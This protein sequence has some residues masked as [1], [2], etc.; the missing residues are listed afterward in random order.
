LLVEVD[1]IRIKT[2][3]NE[4][5]EARAIRRRHRNTMA[6]AIRICVNLRKS[7]VQNSDFKTPQKGADDTQPPAD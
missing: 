5:N 2:E 6:K 7:A 3:A 1:R 4:A